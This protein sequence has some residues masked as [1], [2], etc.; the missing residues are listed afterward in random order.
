MNKELESNRVYIDQLYLDPQTK[1]S[2]SPFK[3][4]KAEFERKELEWMEGQR[5]IGSEDS[6]NK[7][8][9][10]A[11][12]AVTKQ[13][14]NYKLE[15]TRNERTV[16]ERRSTL[17]YLREQLDMQQRSYSPNEEC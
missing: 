14:R 11:F 12:M 1:N 13:S 3:D 2:S 9:M 8:S 16:E 5:V 10:D 15:S 4:T 7:V 6:K 17:G